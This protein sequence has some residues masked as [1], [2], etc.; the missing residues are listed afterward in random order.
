MR[1]HFLGLDLPMPRACATGIF[2]AT[3][4]GLFH[5]VAFATTAN[6]LGGTGN[7][8]DPSK[9]STNPSFPNNNT[10]D[11]TVSSGSVSLDGN[12]TIN[13]FT[14]SGG[15]LGSISSETLNV[16]SFSLDAASGS[17]TINGFATIIA[18]GGV[19]ISGSNIQVATV[20]GSADIVNSGTGIWTA[21]NSYITGSGSAVF[22]NSSGA[23]F[24]VQADSANGFF[25]SGG[26]PVVSN[27]GTFRKSAGSGTFDISWAFNNTGT[28]EA[29]SG[30][31]SLSGG[32]A[33]SYIFQATNAGNVILLNGGTYT[34][35]TGADIEGAGVTRLASG[36]LTLAAAAGTG[37]STFDFAGGT[38]NGTGSLSVNNVLLSGATNFSG[39]ATITGQNG[40]QMA[41]GTGP[42]ASIG[43]TTNIVNHGTGGVWTAS[44]SYLAGYGSGVF[45]NSAGATLDLQVDSDNGFLG[46][47]GTPLVS[48]AGL[49]KKSGGSGNFDISWAFNNTGTLR[50]DSG[51][52]SLSGGGTNTSLFQATNAGNAIVIDVGTYIF[53]AGA[54][55]EGAGVTRLTGNGFLSLIAAAGTGHSTFDFAGG[56][57]NGSGSL[58]VNN[59]LLSGNTNFS[60]GATITGQ[61]G[62]QMTGGI[63]AQLAQ[64]GGLTNIVNNGSGG[65][66]TFSGSF[67]YGYGSAVFTNSAGATLDL[68]VDSA[69][70]FYHAA[71]SP[72]VSNAGLIKKS[73]G[74]GSFTINWVFNNSGTLRVDSGTVSLSGTGANSSLFQATNAGNAILIDSP[75]IFNAG[76]DIEGAG[77]TQ[78]TSNGFLTLMAAT[79]TGHSTF[80]FA[81]G[82]LNGIGSLS[83]NNVLLSGNTNFSGGATITGQTGVQMTGGVNA[84]LAQIGGTTN[85]V[86]N[87]S[88]G[89]WTFSG[90][91][92]Y[93]YGSGLF[94]NSAG[95]TLD[96]QVDS[97]N[98]FY[99]TDGSPQVSNA[100]LIKKSA[101]SGNFEVSW[102]FNNTGTL[103]VDSGTISLDGTVAQYSF[104]TLTLT[105]GTWKAIGSG[106]TIAGSGISVVTTNNGNVVLSGAGST[107]AAIDS[108]R[109]NNGGFTIQN[110]RNFTTTTALANSGHV[111]VGDASTTLTVNGA[112]TQS[113][114]ETSLGTGGTIVAASFS[115]NGGKLDGTGTI[116]GPL[117][118]NGEIAPGNSPGAIGVTGNTILGSSGLLRMEIGGL[119]AGTQ[120]DTLTVTGSFTLGGQLALSLFGGFQTSITSGETFTIASGTSLSGAFSNV[121]NGARLGTTDGLGSFQVN[122]GPSSIFSSNSV[123]LSNFQAVPEPGPAPLLLG[124]VA[125]FL[126]FARPGRPSRRLA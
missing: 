68:Q 24:D 94:T 92:L 21:V 60:G 8:D 76:A 58:S 41:G 121:A 75:Y 43:G 22:T 97:A 101:G 87:G 112:Y 30:T 29:D 53:D 26:S 84:Q 3:T 100:G 77:V 31:I 104:G 115:L 12:F 102:A 16:N 74:S 79:G 23:L 40:V 33:S 44:D 61:N 111:T 20:S 38:L 116:N 114:G 72:Q 80:D 34:F 52:V 73:G 32:G 96:L 65:I 10:F 122:Y 28:L 45:T 71:G 56:T 67:L 47:G 18:A 126:G 108:L 4:A 7:W 118:S 98:G 109:V 106:S 69:N 103:E 42:L 70:G 13:N 113:A 83:V 5:P 2:V 78:L 66:W 50:V 120:Y 55:I 35:N 27:A 86:N 6:W 17:A 91:Y 81:G 1:I 37:H 110:G 63:N 62:V 89:V 85:I 15:T 39:S 93:G 107:F 49:I 48:N 11:A 36:T 95:A 123:V 9:W 46:G 14:L 25:R 124:G 64:I 117:T 88:G 99:Q 125:F 59:V 19:Q 119:N 51:T 90:S 57:L 82:R 54:D 105:G